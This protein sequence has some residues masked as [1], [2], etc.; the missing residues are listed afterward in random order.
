M[1]KVLIGL[2]AVLAI[3][4]SASAALVVNGDFSTGDETGWTHWRAPWGSG[5]TWTVG[6]PG[7][8]AP[9]LTLSAGNASFG[10]FQIVPVPAGELAVLNGEWK[11]T[12]VGWVEYDLFTMATN[13]PTGA[14]N[15]IDTG[16]AADIAFKKDGGSS[17]PSFM[18]A[19]TTTNAGFNG[20]SVVSLGYVVIGLKLGG[21]PTGTASFDN[22][23]L[24]PEPVSLLLLGLPM[25]LIRR[26]RA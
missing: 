19:R 12:T 21:F 24:T 2:V 16:A 9:G 7:N 8:P 23:T 14:A 13:D 6:S 5:E 17:L 26:R 4:A 20:G 18:S 1:K 3:A 22:I 11:L 10:S 15:R 25:L